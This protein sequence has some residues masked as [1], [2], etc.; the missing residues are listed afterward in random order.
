MLMVLG[1]VALNALLAQASFKIDDLQ[2]RVDELS[3]AYDQRSYDAARLASPERIWQAAH[4]IGLV[5][6]AGGIQVLHVPGVGKGKGT[7]H[8]AV[9]GSP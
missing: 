2:Q 7:A 1:L 5:P 6:P 4:D 9:G 8:G 3:Q